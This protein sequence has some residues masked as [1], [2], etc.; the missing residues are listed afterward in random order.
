MKKILIITYYWPPS[1]G[2]GVMRWL[3]F[4]KYLPEMGWQAI[5]FTPENPDPSSIDESLSGE[6]HPETIVLKL[7]IWEPYDL[8]RKLTGKPKEVK[9]KAGYISEASSHGW[10]DKLSVF[11][12]GNFMIPD[13]RKY[14][15][16][17]SVKF[18]LKYL[19]E[20]PVDLI[21]TTG[22]PHSMHLI[23]MQLRK[24]LAIPWMADFRDPWTNIDFYHRLRLTKWADRK[25]RSLEKKVLQSADLVTTVS[26][27][28]AADFKRIIPREIEVITNGFDPED[29]QFK[30]IEPDP[31]F[32]I[33]HIG[34]LNR[35]RN[36]EALWK[37]LGAK[38][39]SD[40]KFRDHLK[41]R[42]VGQTDQSIFHSLEING[43]KD[44]AED[45]GYIDHKKSLA[46]LKQAQVL[47]LPLN[48]APNVA[49]IIPGKLFE[50]LAAER[51]ILVIGPLDGDSARI[52]M[53]TGSGKV[54]GFNDQ[55][56]LRQII[57]EYFQLYL[58]NKLVTNNKEMKKYSRYEL[59]GQL[60]K[61]I[62]KI[63]G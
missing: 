60:V 26:W 61:T 22:P 18:L 35:D 38:V 41:I 50:Y 14:W 11:I 23:G 46:M 40:V 52:I 25:H 32:S 13:P 15:V 44:F 36:P 30:S 28:W 4:S 9:F 12:R 47:L 29:F 10:K 57:D 17:P 58:I 56:R 16:G 63:T 43:L 19:K 45:T 2:G 51:P 42:F 49:G 54:A 53:E 21:V 55:S 33:I 59:T 20:N 8:Y 6:I 48:D 37:V 62:E 1:G 39:I 5:V 31:F 27:S 7:P 24:K 3:K 34:S